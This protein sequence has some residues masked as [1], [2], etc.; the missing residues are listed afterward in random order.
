MTNKISLK[1][2]PPLVKAVLKR[3]YQRFLADCALADG[4]EVTA[5]CP[6]TGAMSTCMTPGCNIYLSQSD[7]PKR[8]YKYTWELSQMPDSL[9]GINTLNANRLVRLALEQ[10][11]VTEISTKGHVKPEAKTGASRL[12]FR[13][14]GA[15]GTAFVEVKNCTLVRDGVAAFPDAVTLRGQKHLEEL[16]RL[17]A[18]GHEAVIFY[19][20]QRTDGKVFR[21]AWDI[22]CRYGELLVEA[23]AAGVKIVVYDTNIN[24]D[25]IS[26]G[27]GL[28]F[29]LSG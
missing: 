23:H 25:E 9:V 6:N 15:R 18:A 21:P 10:G 4:T 20:V 7:N 19:L 24:L 13:V 16:M 26:L 14:D 11:A 2:N 1:F 8:K 22:D 29:D 27:A 12:D 3:R 28:P 5:H 17:N